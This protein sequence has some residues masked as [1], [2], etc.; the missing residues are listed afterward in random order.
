MT[1][2]DNVIE[3]RGSPTSDEIVTLARCWRY[4][5]EHLADAL[6]DGLF[7]EEIPSSQ[8]IDE[9]KVE[10]TRLFIGPG[11]HPCPPYENVYRNAESDSGAGPVLG[12][13]TKS[14]VDWYRRYDLS[15][16]SS[17]TDLPD[18]IAVEL[19]FV[20]HLK[21][22]DPDTVSEFVNEHPQQWMPAFLTDVESHAQNPFYRQLAALT[23][24]TL[25][26][27]T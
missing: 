9:L 13:S 4:P 1:T 5:D 11:D 3:A 24:Q 16:E 19:E 26:S 8:T 10:Y 20:G 27:I 2:T 6:T 7:A 15:P 17:W 18:H 21:E 14:V 12:E 22:D 23:K 25:N